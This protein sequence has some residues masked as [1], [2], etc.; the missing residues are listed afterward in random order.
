LL[1]KQACQ[2]LNQFPNQISNYNVI[3]QASQTHLQQNMK[4]AK[5]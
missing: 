2:T 1:L 4:Q 5:P 3:K